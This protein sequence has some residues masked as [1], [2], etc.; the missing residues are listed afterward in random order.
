MAQQQPQQQNGAKSDEG[1]AQ[2][3]GYRH[4]F[5]E[6]S[7]TEPEMASRDKTY[8]QRIIKMLDVSDEQLVVEEKAIYSIEKFLVARR[9]MYWQ[10]YLHKTGEGVATGADI[11]APAGVEIRREP[12]RR[13]A[14]RYQMHPP[15]LDSLPQRVLPMM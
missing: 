2:G 4:F 1:Q 7:K 3:R 13:Q 8:L 6:A 15:G 11:Q 10:V 12:V 5:E 14:G 9:L